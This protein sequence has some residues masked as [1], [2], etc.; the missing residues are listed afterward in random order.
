[1]LLTSVGPF[2]C[3][4]ATHSTQILQHTDPS[5]KGSNSL[6]LSAS[7]FSRGTLKASLTPFPLCMEGLSAQSSTAC[8]ANGARFGFLRGLGEKLQQLH[9]NNANCIALL[10]HLF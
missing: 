5:L 1:M 6:Q 9:C 8:F 10:M 2:F 7:H 3:L 4:M